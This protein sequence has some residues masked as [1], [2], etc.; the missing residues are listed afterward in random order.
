[1]AASGLDPFTQSFSDSSGKKSL[2]QLQ[3]PSDLQKHVD[4]IVAG[5]QAHERQWKLNLAFYKGRQYTYY[6]RRSNKIEQLPVED[7]EKPRYRVRLVSNQ[8]T[9][10]V[11]SHIAMLLKTKPQPMA[12]PGSASSSDLQA[13]EMAGRL[14]EF[15]WDDFHLDDALEEALI[16]ADVAGQGF[17]KVDWDPNAGKQMTFMVDPQGNP[18]LDDSAKEQFTAQ[19]AQIGVEPQEQVVYMG[20]IRVQV[21][22]PFD[23]LIDP[24]A[25]RFDEAKYVYEVCYMDPDAIKAEYGVDLPADAVT[26]PPDVGLPFGNLDQLPKNVR[27]VITGYFLPQPSLPK[28]RIVTWAGKTMLRDGQWNFPLNKL[29]FFKFPGVRI[30]GEL[31]DTSVVEQAIPLQKELNRTISQIVE[32]KNLTARPQWMAPTGSLRQRR[33]DEP[34]AVFLYNPI[35]PAGLKPEPVPLG[36]LPSYVFTHLESIQSRLSDIFGLNQI[37][38]GTPPPN[39]E[40]GVAIDLLQEMAVDRFAPSLRLMELALESAGRF[41]LSLAKEYYVEPRIMKIRGSGG[42]YQVYQ[43]TKADINGAV[44]VQVETGSSLPRTRAGRQ[45]RIMEFID[46][47]IIAP[48][49]AYKY[50]DIAD[51]K[52]LQAQ[53]AQDE[54][55]AYR[56]NEKLNQGT[57]ISQ[58]N[59]Y[60]AQQQIQQLAQTLEQFYGPPAPAQPGYEWDNPEAPPNPDT[61]QP[62][63]SWEDFDQWAQ[64]HMQQAAVQANM[65]DNHNV[66]IDVHSRFMKSSEYEQMDVQAQQRYN[67][68]VSSH[69]NMMLMLPASTQGEA[70]KINLQLKSTVGPTTQAKILEKA[71]VYVTPEDTSEPP[72]ETWLSDSV[73]QPDADTGTPGAAGPQDLAQWAQIIAESKGTLMQQ[74]QQA[75]TDAVMAQAQLHEKAQ[76]A[77]QSEETHQAKMQMMMAKIANEKKKASQKPKESNGG[78]K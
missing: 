52:G 74:N 58:I 1:M 16:W 27:K 73:D 65:T 9:P 19:L 21:I 38:Q 2:S 6:N 48:D 57:P 75:G 59:V 32:F 55:Q 76:K 54:D 36:N 70:P 37:A 28:G 64:Q 26:S 78:K 43:F 44:D 66:H 51:L 31:Y 68:H 77:R 39:V 34:G 10:G 12:T 71:G 42:S 60:N 11:Q 30:P 29:P 3:K 5:R 61:N 47:G 7:G 63:V 41:M 18:I 15:W 56:E 35:G 69:Y 33:T 49:Q 40:A 46:R 53:F 23:L 14:L 62:F 13:A 22:S 24:S 45:S 72:L 17:W 25:R 4:E 67:D 20:D 50:L 8:I